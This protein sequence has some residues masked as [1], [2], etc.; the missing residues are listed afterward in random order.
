MTIKMYYW[1]EV[2]GTPQFVGLGQDLQF[3][4]LAEKPVLYQDPHWIRPHI[5]TY[6]SVNFE[7]LF[8]LKQYGFTIETKGRGT[9]LYRNEGFADP[10][11]FME[12]LQ[13]LLR[14]F[15]PIHEQ[16]KKLEE[17]WKVNMKY[18]RMIYEDCFDALNTKGLTTKEKDA[19]RDYI[20]PFCFDKKSYEWNGRSK[21]SNTVL[22]NLDKKGFPENRATLVKTDWFQQEVIPQI[23]IFEAKAGWKRGQ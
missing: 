23:E 7:P 2:L 16:I 5:E 10:H 13:G 18:R 8:I 3:H 14:W 9:P 17:A 1:M 4:T 22:R 12:R 15:A 6:N 21:V 19:L 20:L 11:E